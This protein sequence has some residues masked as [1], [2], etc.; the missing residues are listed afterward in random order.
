[1]KKTMFLFFLLMMFALVPTSFAQDPDHA[2]LVHFD[3]AIEIPGQVLQPGT[4]QF[5]ALDEQPGI[6]QVFDAHRTKLYAMVQSYSATRLDPTDN[7]QITIADD[8]GKTALMGWFNPGETTGYEFAYPRDEM[9]QLSA[10]QR[11]VEAGTLDSSAAY[12]D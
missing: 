7:V 9:K 6:V 8:N 12:G 2:V 3:Q 11:G 1:M 4:Y 5:V 10:N